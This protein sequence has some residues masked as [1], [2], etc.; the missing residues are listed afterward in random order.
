MNATI[1]PTAGDA[2]P[3]YGD[4]DRRTVEQTHPLADDG[5]DA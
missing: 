3:G 2:L 5:G 1:D 4:S